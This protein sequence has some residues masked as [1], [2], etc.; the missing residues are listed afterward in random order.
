M[1]IQ[2]F[3]AAVATLALVF[4][5]VCAHPLDLEEYDDGSGS[6]PDPALSTSK[7]YDEWL[8]LGSSSTTPDYDFKNH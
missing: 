3:L 2:L 4:S 6:T 7:D 8:Y 5:T 1:K